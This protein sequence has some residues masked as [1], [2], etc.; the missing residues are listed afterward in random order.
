M[1]KEILKILD[2]KYKILTKLGSG[3]TSSVYLCESL[4]N[5]NI[6]AAKILKKKSLDI[7]AEINS[8]SMINHLNIVNL[9]DSGEGYIIENEKKKFVKYLILEYCEKGALID[10]ML[11][12][13]KG[14]G[15]EIGRGIFKIIL[16]G[17]KAIHEKEITHRDLKMKNI[18]LNKDF[19]IKIADFGFS[20]SIFNDKGEKK[21]SSPKGTIIYMAPEILAGQQYNGEKVDIFS[22]GVMLFVIVTCKLGFEMATKINEKYKLI[23]DKE[24][25]KYWKSVSKQIPPVSFNFKDLYLKMVSFK[26]EERPT[27]QEIFE[28]P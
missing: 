20:R 26:P 27:L 14:F 22:L 8:L 24:F 15:E 13:E 3:G 9:I 28:H 11:Y 10:Y 1:E 7:N 16:N 19:I 23:K 17:V 6:Y 18:L 21:L 2:D 25:D 4:S 12:P 5:K